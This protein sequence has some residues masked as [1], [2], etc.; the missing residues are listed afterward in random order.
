MTT[1]NYVMNAA[2]W[3]QKSVGFPKAQTS[4]YY[5]GLNIGG[6]VLWPGVSR[7]K[8]KLFFFAATEISQQHVDQ[9][10]RKAAVPTKA[11]RTGDFSNVWDMDLSNA[12]NGYEYWPVATY[13]CGSGQSYCS[14]SGIIVPTSIDPAGQILLSAFPLPNVDPLKNA[15]NNLITDLVTSDPRNQE[16]L[17][18]DYAMTDNT[19]ASLRYNHENESVPWPS[20][21][22]NVWNQV[23]YPAYQTGKNASNSVTLELTNTLSASVTN[24]MAL[25]YTRFSLE[26]AISNLSAVSLTALKYPYPN[27]FSTASGIIPNVDFEGNSQINNDQLYIGGGEVPPFLGVQ[28]TYTYNEA[29]TKLMK[30]HLIKA[31]FYTEVAQ[32]NNLTTGNDNGSVSMQTYCGTTGNDWADL[33]LGNT[34]EWSQ[35]SSNI[36]ALMQANRFGFLLRTLGRLPGS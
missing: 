24:Q 31:G 6:P 32:F 26:E 4:L 19:H 18:M 17:R 22:Y 13:P 30:N 1:R 28:N 34:C 12:A 11:M 7:D 5:P 14:G 3:Q 21:P 16:I 9:G 8:E 27:L 23:P 10:V 15:G 36:M 20:G 2:D 25:G 35:S 33:L 29:L